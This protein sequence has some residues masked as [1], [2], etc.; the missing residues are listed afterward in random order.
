MY[1]RPRS[2]LLGHLHIELTVT[3]MPFYG[4]TAKSLFQI[5]RLA[6]YCCRLS[7]INSFCLP[8]AHQPTTLSVGGIETIACLLDL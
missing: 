5:H 8:E 6:I 2:T 4:F 3:G 1:V 7:E